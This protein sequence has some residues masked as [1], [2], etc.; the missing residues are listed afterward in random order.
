MLTDD[1]N[2]LL[3]DIYV[4][5]VQ[6]QG[7]HWTVTGPFFGALHTLFGEF[8]EEHID[9]IDLIAERVRALESNPPITLQGFISNSQ[10]PEA[11]DIP[12]YQEMISRLLVKNE[13]IAATCDEIAKRNPLDQATVNLLADLAFAAGRRAWKLRAHLT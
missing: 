10:F 11:A 8:Y 13:V 5:Y 7:Y 9:E 2:G 12:T 4:V 1:L 6:T 3:S